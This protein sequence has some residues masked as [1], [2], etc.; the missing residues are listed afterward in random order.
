[1]DKLSSCN[2]KTACSIVEAA[3]SFVL[4][5][6]FGSFVF[7]ILE[8]FRCIVRV[9]CSGVVSL[10][11]SLCFIHAFLTARRVNFSLYS[12]LNCLCNAFVFVQKDLY[13]ELAVTE[14]EY[15]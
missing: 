2:S 14:T 13:K 4:C 15:R 7:I 12:L 9:R 11:R 8:T 5:I 10:Q 6:L 3:S 1:M